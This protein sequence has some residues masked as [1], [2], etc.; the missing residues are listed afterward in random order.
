MPFAYIENV[1]DY[2]MM[3]SKDEFDTFFKRACDNTISKTECDLSFDIVSKVFFRNKQ[4]K[5]IQSD[6]FTK[7]VDLNIECL[8]KTFNNKVY[9]CNQLTNE[10]ILQ[11]IEDMTMLYNI[12]DYCIQNVDTWSMM[13]NEDR[14]T[15]FEMNKWMNKIGS[16]FLKLNKF[17][18]ELYRRLV[19][20]FNKYT[21]ITTFTGVS[22]EES[23]SD[24]FY[25]MY[26]LYYM[27]EL[28]KVSKN[29]I[30]SQPSVSRDV[31]VNTGKYVHISLDICFEMFDYLRKNQD[32]IDFNL[33]LDNYIIHSFDVLSTFFTSEHKMTDYIQKEP[34]YRGIF[35]Y[36]KFIERNIHQI[37]HEG[38]T[39]ELY[40][41]MYESIKNAR[42]ISQSNNTVFIDHRII[43]N[44]ETMMN[45]I[46]EKKKMNYIDHYF[47][48]IR[49]SYI[50]H[51]IQQVRYTDLSDFTQ[52]KF[53]MMTSF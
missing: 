47:I 10:E 21:D 3:M 27:M 15:F 43:Q 20:V 33:L 51:R 11:C 40:L 25:F 52:K 48:R 14:Y 30:E 38:M 8:Q 28:F 32:E 36:M 13:T 46:I 2:R 44:I 18:Y 50:I 34:Y 39:H 24:K 4:T 19:I 31:F 6:E 7:I 1:D 12:I 9:I 41:K 49:C 16:I 45:H 5:D 53:N 26:H 22:N 23:Y 35:N 29:N 42:I 37:Y 17:A